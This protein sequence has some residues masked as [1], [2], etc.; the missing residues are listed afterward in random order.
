M[1][2][3]KYRKYILSSKKISQ[4]TVSNNWNK[5]MSNCTRSS[6]TMLYGLKNLLIQN[7]T[8]Q[9]STPIPPSGFVGYKT[10]SDN[11][12]GDLT[13]YFFLQPTSS[14]DNTTIYCIPYSLQGP[15]F[16]GTC[17][18]GKKRPPSALVSVET[19]FF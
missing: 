7:N 16:T 12:C 13:A 19:F 14:G 3:C 5:K 11:L 8:C 4:K 18:S 2:Q 9:T 1:E 6:D 15:F 10:Y 17:K